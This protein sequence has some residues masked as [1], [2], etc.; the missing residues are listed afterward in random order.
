MFMKIKATI[1]ATL[2]ALAVATG[3]ALAA[4]IVRKAPPA[5]VAPPPPCDLAFGGGVQSDY[6]FRGISQTDRGPGVWAYAEPRCKVAPNIELYAGIWGWSTKLPTAPTGE[7][8]L[9][10]GI[11]PTIGPLAFD[12][13][14]MYY[15][16]PREKQQF[17]DPSGAIILNQLVPGGTILTLSDS[18]MWEFY[19]K[20][21][22]TATDWLAVGGYVYYT[23]SWLNTGAEG[24]YA[25]GT[26]KVTMPSAWFPADVGAY[27]S[28]EAAHY[29]L[30]TATNFSPFFASFD[31]PDYTYWNAGLGVTYKVFTFDLRYHDTS[32]TKEQCFLLTSD[33]SGVPSG[34]SKWCGAAVIGKF[35]FDLTALTNLK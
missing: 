3:S 17:L 29:W 12:F 6:N 1:A 35:S 20:V 34:Q 2:T 28:A 24:T 11:R 18:D 30:G 23:P 9:Y 14:F 19:G 26:V 16:Y 22:W 10:G 31:L 32:L 4:D 25:G 15:W 7:F 33:P 8:D 21:T 5:P 13:G 27:V